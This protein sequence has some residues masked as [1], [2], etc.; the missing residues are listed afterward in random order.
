M[1][2]NQTRP[3]SSMR[4][5]KQKYCLQRTRAAASGTVVF[6][7]KPRRRSP[8]AI[9]E[10]R[11]RSCPPTTVSPYAAA[12][13][14]R[15]AARRLPEPVALPINGYLQDAPKQMSIKYRRIKWLTLRIAYM[16]PCT[17]HSAKYH[18]I[19]FYKTPTRTNNP[20]GNMT[21][22]PVREQASLHTPKHAI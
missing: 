13:N 22:L 9:R 5:Y 4:L 19:S 20:F 6:A 8:G 1:H 17:P 21:F 14:T 16:Y 18:L 2:S 10:T 3:R 15:T 11:I 7:A 12:P